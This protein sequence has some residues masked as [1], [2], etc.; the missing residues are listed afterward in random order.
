LNTW[1][2]P[3]VATKKIARRPAVARLARP[4]EAGQEKGE[5]RRALFAAMFLSGASL[6]CAG[7]DLP[8]R[9]TP[10]QPASPLGGCSDVGRALLRYHGRELETCGPPD[11]AFREVLPI[12]HGRLVIRE[13][14]SSRIEL[15]ASRPDGTFGD[16]PLAANIWADP[17]RTALA[18]ALAGD[19]RILTYDQRSGA[20]VAYQVDVAARLGDSLLRNPVD[21]GSQ[22]PLLTGRDL[23]ALDD[24]HLLDWE[25]GTGRFNVWRVDGTP[26]RPVT[27][28]PAPFAGRRDHLRRGHRLV[29]L[30]PGRLLDWVPAT[31][32]FR[33][34]AVALNAGAPEGAAATDPFADQ[35]IAA[36][37]WTRD[38]AGLAPDS[39]LYVVD[40]GKLLIWE[41]GTGTLETRSFD[42]DGPD[43]L[44]GAVLGRATYERLRSAPRVREPSTRAPS[45][46]RVVIVFLEP[47]RSFDH[48][49]G[50]YCRGI[51]TAGGAP[52]P[53]NAGPACCEA[54]PEAI[55][56]AERCAPVDPAA[57]PAYA[58]NESPACMQAKINGGEMNR[59]AVAIPEVADCGDARDFACLHPDSA[60]TLGVFHRLAE[61]GAL[62]DRFFQTALGPNWV[63]VAPADVNAIYFAKAAFDFQIA[64]V[65][66]E[67]ITSLLAGRHVGWALY[68]RDPR[69]DSMGQKP[70][71]FYD[72]R[73][74]H[75]R[76][77]DDEL[78]NDVAMEELAPVT[79]V[80]APA[81]DPTIG[82]RLV[83]D[84][85]RALSTSPRY[86]DDTLILVGYL[87]AGGYYDH[88][89][90]PE[91]PAN[92]PSGTVYGP[93]VPLMAVGG[94]A[95]AGHVS[96]VPLEVS[97]L[98]RFLEYNWFD[99]ATGQLNGRDRTAHNICDLL[100]DPGEGCD[101]A[102]SAASH[103]P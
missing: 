55:P 4:A 1:D 62:A 14:L 72:A 9:S 74:S 76:R 33:V 22:A 78:L 2:P 32:A 51:A 69:A 64:A 37:V 54:M 35:P 90:P 85:V 12:G 10:D 20:F 93:R 38:R 57:P 98:T 71:T 97:S 79:A 46:R 42:P 29:A 102:D 24:R 63:G 58:P 99:G 66:G 75:F 28:V 86:R 13:T 95:R 7:D 23:L 44:A 21:A 82:A 56:G 53:C 17:D 83:D 94:P 40:D 6:G 47:G 100:V 77:I 68:L 60:G 49:F 11:L 31:G 67:A 52:P 80:R 8:R 39:E 48:H 96:H 16:G 81:G 91:P 43:P 50:R 92:D 70:P 84:L 65:G 61:R 5:M 19:D 36:G 101:Q 25:P 30:A 89:P 45:V 87:T 41:R 88:V 26:E 3:R 73:W 59:F 34:W 18:V 15:W 27:L 103:T